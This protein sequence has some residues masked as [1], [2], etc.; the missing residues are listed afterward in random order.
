MQCRYLV[1]QHSL[2]FNAGTAWDGDKKDF[3]CS[4]FHFKTLKTSSSP[5]HHFPLA[6][7]F[8]HISLNREGRSGTTDVLTTSFL[9]FSLFSTVLLDLA[10]SKPVHF[11]TLSSHLLFCLPCLHPP[12]IVH[13]RMVLTM[14]GRHDHT[15][16]V[17]ISLRWSGGLRVVR[18]PAGSWHGL[19]RW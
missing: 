12:L 4:L 16:A 5:P 3:N 14:K 19:P 17:W 1:K 13:C 15:T 8:L 11:L 7:T 9:H 10:N 2:L 18:L 6:F